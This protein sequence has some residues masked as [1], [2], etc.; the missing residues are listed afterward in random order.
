M[1]SDARRGDP[2]AGVPLLAD[3]TVA[4]GE[5]WI[6]SAGFNV[7]PDLASTGR[8]DSELDDLRLLSDAGARVAVLS[9]QGSHRDGSAT[10]LDHIAAYLSRRLDRPVR[11]VPENASDAAV[12]EAR[13][14][15]PGDI[16]LF[17]NTRHHAGEERGDDDL[18]R[19]F[20]LL[21]DRVAVGG[22]SKAHRAHASNTGLL[23][24]LP[25]YAARSLVADVRFMAPWCDGGSPGPSAAV[26]G[27][28]K[29][30]KTCVGLVHALRTCA[31]VVPGGVVLNTVLRALGHE[32][33][34]SDTGS[35][36]EACLDA[37]RTALRTG[38]RARLHVPATVRAAPVNGRR[39]T[40][41]ATPVAVADGVPPGHAIVDFA[42]EPWAARMLARMSRTVVAGT[43]SRYLDGHRG[44]SDAIL[45]ALAAAP[46]R[47][48]LL[49]G[50]TVAELPWDGPVSTGGGSALHLLS[51]GT[52]AV[53]DALRD[54]AARPGQDTSRA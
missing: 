54:N 47:T 23:R 10:A 17:G 49:G 44:S 15:R 14:L 11:Y 42:L 4:P 12:E 20:A 53:L 33:G 51:T 30:E 1:V 36:P 29:K 41:A 16:A 2:L 6:H 32:I 35:H 25:G 26:L 45:S 28:R 34:A 52:C 24:R 40:G 8:V 13:R 7:G 22:F 31:L 48:L 5:R 27:G 9:H 38:G 43:P 46:G 50:D 19:R 37:A 18:A 3:R 39:I 21:G